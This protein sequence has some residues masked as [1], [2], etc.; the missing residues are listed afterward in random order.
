MSTTFTAI[1]KQSGNWW[2]GWIGEVPGVNAEE[3]T[4]QELLCSL[5][6]ILAGALECK[7]AEAR[8]AA[9]GTCT[10]EPVVV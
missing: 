9:E 10:E 2:I 7:R 5:K 3:K 1:I 4:K 6:E 8:Q